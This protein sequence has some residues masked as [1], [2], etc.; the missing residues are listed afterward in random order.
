MLPG[1]DVWPSK[2]TGNEHVMAPIAKHAWNTWQRAAQ[3]HK[4]EQVPAL[5]L[6][7]GRYWGIGISTAIA[8]THGQFSL[9]AGDFLLLTRTL[10]K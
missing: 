10:F 5:L 6:A 9:H 8:S 4:Q 3:F 1:K 7:P 2:L